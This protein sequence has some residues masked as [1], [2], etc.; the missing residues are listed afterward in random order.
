MSYGL[1]AIGF[2]NLV[3]RA[4]ALDK[5]GDGKISAKEAEDDPIIATLLS[6]GEKSP[7]EIAKARYLTLPNELKGL[8]NIN[9]RSKQILENRHEFG[10]F[11]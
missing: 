10:N 7:E 3:M 9:D 4:S 5:N 8:G 6:G 11:S 2:A 1:D